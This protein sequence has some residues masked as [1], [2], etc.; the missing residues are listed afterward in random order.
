MGTR[1]PSVGTAVVHIADLLVA[2]LVVTG[3]VYFFWHR[4]HELRSE[5]RERAARR[6]G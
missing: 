4:I 5:A 1:S 6:Q 2:A 3:G